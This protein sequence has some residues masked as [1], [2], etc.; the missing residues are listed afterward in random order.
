MSLQ[1]K[2]KILIINT[3]ATRRNGITGVIFNYLRAAEGED[4]Q[5]DLLS[6][7]SPDSFYVK[8][9]KVRRQGHRYITTVEK[10]AKLLV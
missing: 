10:V 3:V 9:R 8:K 4:L 6:L 5:M 7:N 2:P 1:K